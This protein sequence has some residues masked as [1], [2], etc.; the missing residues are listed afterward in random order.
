MSGYPKFSVVIPLY[1]KA[2]SIQKTLKSV[3]SQRFEPKEI[4]VVDD[5]STDESLAQVK[6][7]KSDKIRILSQQNQGVSAA[8]NNG[9]AVSTCEYIAFLDG[10]DLW[11]PFH[12]QTL[13]DLILRFP[14]SAFF[15]TAYQKMISE[16][17]FVDPKLSTPHFSPKGGLLLNYFDVA[18]RG[19][20]PFMTSSCAITRRL[21]D[22][23][24]GFPLNEA[25][26]EDQALFAAAALKT[27][28]AYSPLVR[29]YYRT[30]AENRACDRHLPSAVLPFAQ[31]LLLNI[32]S[33][34]R[35]LHD[36]VRRYC[37]AHAC[38]LVKLHLLRWDAVTAAQILE[39]AVCQP[40]RAKRIA[41]M[42]WCCLAK[43]RS[44]FGSAPQLES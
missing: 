12:L 15:A 1:N 29:L 6:A 24:G 10:D 36:D 31:R 13:K 18:S 43:V 3:L 41:L 25:M 5:G 39:Q 14:Q 42:A 4:I 11:S 23:I 30:D 17:C 38:H 34:P 35:S 37:A 2:E 44:L 22:E 33:L 7:L 21:F 28:I 27:S 9:V 20:L 19:D 16:N 40:L 8:R 32:D 26:G